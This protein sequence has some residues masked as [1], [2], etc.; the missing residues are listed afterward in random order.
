M[1]L[2]SEDRPAGTVLDP[3]HVLPVWMPADYVPGEA[4]WN[5]VGRTLRAPGFTGE[6]LRAERLQ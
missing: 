6:M 3:S 5:V 4:E 1:P 2:L